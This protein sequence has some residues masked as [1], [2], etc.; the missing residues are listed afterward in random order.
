MKAL[1]ASLVLLA[2]AA[3]AQSLV[4]L[5]EPALDGIGLSG[6]TA[7]VGDSFN[8]DSSIVGACHTVTSSACSG[9]GCQ[10]VTY[11]TNYIATWDATGSATSVQACSVIR[12]H[13]PQA[14]QVTYLDGHSA[15][16]CPSVVFNRGSTVEINGTPYYYVST[17]VNGDE[18]VNSN[19]AGYLV[20]P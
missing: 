18:L 2:S 12:H 20:L 4:P 13:S 10:P 3:Q 11:T 7:C 8:A 15:V 19:A 5:T 16:D 6:R 1:I 14:D 17:S 9:R